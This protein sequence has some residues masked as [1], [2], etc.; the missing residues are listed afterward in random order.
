M[1][2]AH[3]L[4]AMN[5][6]RM[7]GMNSQSTAKSTEKLSS[8][9][10]INR[11]ADD[12][13]G[14]AVSEKMRRQIRGLRQGANNTTDGVSWVKI[15]DGAMNEVNDMLNRMTELS[16]KAANGTMSDSDR[17]A[18]DSE[19]KQL[20]KEI[21]R[22][23]ATTVF[24][25]IPI[26]DNTNY[27]PKMTIEGMP[28]GLELFDASYDD[29]TGEFSFGGVI[30]DGS[31]ISWNEIHPDMVSMDADGN[32]VFRPG[33]Y[34][35]AKNGMEFTVS[36]KEGA[37]GPDLTRE[38]AVTADS[39][40]ISFAGKAFQWENL[41]D[42]D[43][44]PAGKDNVHS[45][46]WTLHCAG[47][48][49]SFH[50]PQEVDTLEEL[51]DAMNACV[52][53]KITQTIR[54]EYIG[55]ADETAVTSSFMQ[56]I[57][58][59]NELAAALTSVHDFSI[60][61]NA[62]ETGIWLQNADGTDINNSKLTWAEMGIS[63]WDSGADISASRTYSYKYYSGASKDKPYLA[64]DFS[65]SD[66]TSIDSVIDGLNGMELK[67]GRITTSYGAAIKADITSPGGNTDI[68]KF[69]SS[70][71]NIKVSFEEEIDLGR[72]FDSKTDAVTG[73]VKIDVQD[74]NNVDTAVLT[75]NGTNGDITYTGDV[76]GVETA[77]ASDVE[78]YLDYIT[79]WAREAALAGT[80]LDHYIIPTLTDLVGTANITTSGHFTD[81]VTVNSNMSYTPGK[82]DTRP[83][84]GKTYPSA[85]I[86]FS[87]VKNLDDLLLKGFDS[88]C[89][90]CDTHYSVVFKN[91]LSST[92]EYNYKAEGL[93]H[94]L[95]ISL[96]AL[97]NRVAGGETIAEVLV[98][99]MSGVFDFHYTQYAAGD[100]N[101]SP[102]DN[103]TLYIFDYRPHYIGSN[104]AD[105]GTEPYNP[106]GQSFY[107][108]DLSSADN[109]S[110][111]LNYTYDFS[112]ASKHLEVQM[113]PDANGEYVKNPSGTYSKYDPN[114][115]AG[116]QRYTPATVY[117][118][119]DGNA[120]TKSEAA[121]SYAKNAVKD[122]LSSTTV[123][124]DAKDYTYMQLSGKENTNTAV[125]GLFQTSTSIGAYT[126]TGIRIQHSAEA[127][128]FTEIP[129]F[130][131]NT[132]ALGLSK[133]GTRT[134]AQ[135][136]ETL[137]SLAAASNYVYSKRA[138]YGAYQNRL[139]HT[140]NNL[141]NTVE[142]T[143]A[144]DSRIRDTDM[145]DE[146]VRYSNYNILQQAGQ[147]M[148]AQSNQSNQGV[149]SLLS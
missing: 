49:V 42:E 6:N 8:G 99:I 75:F 19:I 82:S 64:F 20:K 125:R 38:F 139:E 74:I 118:D 70:A 87:A 77:M 40:G 117:K 36:W 50:I 16:V 15:G 34:T 113:Q 57:W 25:E 112:K 98:D 45:G 7:L 90:T 146:M 52:S 61:V 73:D 13:A 121:A 144:A 108:V 43:G 46:N 110:I 55:N 148:S 71:N 28:G 105:F 84:P 47:S 33:E 122:M 127:D 69:T 5:A 114:T 1:I 51:A 128:D 88:T 83:Q 86:D 35:Y 56:H 120:V 32:Q 41:V 138:L 149:M 67:D 101:G 37:K 53:E 76:S 22:V 10:K 91:G 126:E 100:P 93:N 106:A 65:L 147:S 137:D 119:A 111:Q 39:S 102:R 95:E 135:A 85:F 18:V 109:G 130:A 58:I 9:Y 97:K 2:V 48:S 116:K 44:Q 31:R 124:L 103:N 136:L 3:N 17:E 54:N 26:F 72:D 129:R 107:S 132:M 27:Q 92:V 104:G 80:T 81:Q 24:N 21:D 89:M 68:K 66:V 4:P 78:S 59:S 145:A 133:A 143:E 60:F 29:A 23:S 141:L 12:A 94:T 62:D 30:F 11:A 96:D 63:S 131:L 123:S 140:Y 14:L 134:V 115:D 79:M 142:N